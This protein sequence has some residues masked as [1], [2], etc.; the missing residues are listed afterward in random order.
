MAEDSIRLLDEAREEGVSSTAEATLAKAQSGSRQ[1]W[2]AKLNR[3][4]YGEG[5][6]ATEVRVSIQELHLDALRKAG[7]RDPAKRSYPEPVEAEYE[8]EGEH[9]GNPRDKI[10]GKQPGDS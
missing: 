10:A 3:A 2:A 9:E 8:I 1:W 7:H 4:K 5:R 6:Q